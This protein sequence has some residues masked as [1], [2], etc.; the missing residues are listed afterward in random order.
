[1][2]RMILPVLLAGLGLNNPAQGAPIDVEAVANLN[3]PAVLVIEG[4]RADTGVNVQG[5]GCCISAEGFVLATA[6]QAE[7]VTDFVGRLADGTKVPLTLIESRP[8]VEFALFKATTPLPAFTKLG[9]AEAL[10]SGA[11]V[12]S[13]AAPMNLEFSTVSGTIANANRTFNGYSVLQVALTASHGSSGGP[14]FDRDGE[15]IGLIS[16]GFNDIDFTIVNKINNAFSLLEVHG[17]RRTGMDEVASSDVRLVPAPGASEPEIRAIEAYNRG[18]AAED[19]GGKIKAY[20]LAVTLLPTFYEAFFNLAVV[21]ASNGATKDAV[22]HYQRAVALKPDGVE[23]RRNLGRLYLREKSYDS[24]IDI[25]QEVVKLLPDDARGYNDL[26]EAYRRAGRVDEAI[27]QFSESLQI[28]NDAPAVHYNLALAL[29]SADKA[30]EAIQHFEAYLA[31]SPTAI[32]ANDVRAWIEKL[33][34]P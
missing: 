11:P 1:M 8:E 34:T 18:V 10:N 17:L 9:D 27:G 4:K 29:V 30:P 25:F 6:H 21:E 22:E 23:A 12:V 3:M 13:I 5:S 16:G 2:I 20:G 31:L 28:K 24:A 14:V 7:G 26:G 19:A 15:L 32:D 33:K